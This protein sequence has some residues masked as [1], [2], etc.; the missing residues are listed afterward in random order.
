MIE[1]IL[2]LLI[3][4]LGVASFVIWAGEAIVFFLLWLVLWP[5]DWAL[6]FALHWKQSSNPCYCDACKEKRSR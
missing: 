3:V 6:A 4:I 5:I 1:F 2:L